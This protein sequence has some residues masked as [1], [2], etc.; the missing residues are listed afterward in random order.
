MRSNLAP[1]ALLLVACHASGGPRPAVGNTPS[2]P[3]PA[4]TGAFMAGLFASDRALVYDVTQEASYYDDQDPAA[5]ASGMVHRAATEPVTCQLTVGALGGYRT[6]VIAC[7][8]DASDELIGARVLEELERTY[9]TDGDRLWRLE[10]GERPTTVD[11]LEAALPDLPDLTRDQRPVEA[12]GDGDDDDGD[13]DPDDG[14]DDERFGTSHRVTP[15]GDGWCVADD[16]WG[17]DEGGASWCVSAARGITRVSWYFA[18]GST[19]DQKAEL[20]P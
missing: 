4:A 16:S 10:G 13:G 8:S 15:A 2:P 11:E 17:G 20:R 18:G 12:G 19:Q 14:A 6:A 5:D 9:V 3:P 1:A 7:A